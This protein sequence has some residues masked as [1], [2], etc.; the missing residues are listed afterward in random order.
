MRPLKKVQFC[1]EPMKAKILTIPVRSAG[2]TG[3]AGIHSVFRKL[4]FETEAGTG[5]ERMFF[6]GLHI[7]EN[8]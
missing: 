6:R 8:T 2:P 5:Q 3:Q 4:K 7:R 1:S